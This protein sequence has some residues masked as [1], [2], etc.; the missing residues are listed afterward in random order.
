MRM[1]L[2]LCALVALATATAAY[3]K[4]ISKAGD[5]VVVQAQDL[6]SA[7]LAGGESMTLHA[8]NNGLTY[9]YIEQHS[10]HRVVVMDVTDPTRIRQVGAVKIDEPVFDF[11]ARAGFSGVLIRYRDGQ[12]LA[13]MSFAHPRAPKITQLDEAL[14]GS[15]AEAINENGLMMIAGAEAP[16]SETPRD[17]RVVDASATPSLQLLTTVRSVHAEL[18]MYDTGTMFLLGQDGLTVVR[19]PEVEL[20]NWLM[21]NYAD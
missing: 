15:E 12:R 19:Q 16:G 3:G 18:G 4:V 17:Y 20:R 6:P 8:L 2:K 11:G 21:S 9:L 13:V 10:L 1:C 14:A 5:I 7:A